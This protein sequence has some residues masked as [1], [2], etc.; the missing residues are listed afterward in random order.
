MNANPNLSGW[1]QTAGAL[2]ALL[3]AIAVPWM[4]HAAQN[5]RT[6]LMELEHNIYLSQATMLLLRDAQN[7]NERARQLA[8]LPKHEIHDPVMVTDLL[9]R[10]R[11]LDAKDN[12][13]PRQTSQYVAR[14]AVLRVNH[15][16]DSG[17][18]RSRELSPEVLKLLQDDYSYMENEHKKIEFLS[19][20]FQYEQA[21]L[22]V[23]WLKR[24]IVWYAFKTKAGQ[25]WLDEM[26][27]KETQKLKE[28][29][30]IQPPG[31]SVK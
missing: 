7:L 3:I 2:F 1:A 30:G 31:D 15:Y 26:S 4:Q 25:L 28:R 13:V 5:R 9:E 24:P 11:T 16:L 8:D 22:Q 17:Q 29:Q 14:A 10:L 6:K 21:K 23:A 12:S 19:E 18:A 27:A 20:E